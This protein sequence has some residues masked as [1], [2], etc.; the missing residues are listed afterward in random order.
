[1]GKVRQIRTAD[2]DSFVDR[3][4]QAG[5]VGS[6]AF[7][8]LVPDFDL[9]L[10]TKIDESL[11]P[12]GEAYVQQQ[13]SI[14]SEISGRTLDQGKWEPQEFDLES[15]AASPCANPLGNP[16]L[17]RHLRA[18]SS[19]SELL[20][21]NHPFRVLDMGCGLGLSSEHFAQLGG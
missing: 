21:P 4:D 9:V 12:F 15:V 1:M 6:D 5:G 18:L 13:I 3:V 10:E 7:A 14:W 20:C 19:V 2:L 11:D 17:S 8:D 16:A